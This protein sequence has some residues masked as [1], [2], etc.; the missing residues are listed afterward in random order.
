MEI[1]NGDYLL[2]C[3]F[4][5]SSFKSILL[6]WITKKHYHVILFLRCMEYPADSDQFL[7]MHPSGKHVR[8]MY[9]AP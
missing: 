7:F 2:H 8:A 5:K 3:I 1:E 6:F 4:N 9:I